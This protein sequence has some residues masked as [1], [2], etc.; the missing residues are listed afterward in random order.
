MLNIE[1]IQLS[2]PRFLINKEEGAT[3]SPMPSYVDMFLSNNTGYMNWFYNNFKNY[4][5]DLVPS[6]IKLGEKFGTIGIP[7]QE[8]LSQQPD[9]TIYCIGHL[10]LSLLPKRYVKPLLENFRILCVD[11]MEGRQFITS[12]IANKIIQYRNEYKVRE[13]VDQM[14]GPM[15]GLVT[16]NNV[17]NQYSK[18]VFKYNPTKLAVVPCH[19]PRPGRLFM[20]SEL[21]KEDLL[22]DCD[23]TLIPDFSEEISDEALE[24][25]KAGDGHFYLSPNLNFKKWPLLTDN[26]YKDIQNFLNTYRND[27]PKSFDNLTNNTFSDSCFSVSMDFLGAHMFNVSCETRDDICNDKDI[28]ITEKTFKAFLYATPCLV[29]GSPNIEKKLSNY[30][31]KFPSKS[32]YDHLH[33]MER[34]S[35]MVDFLKQDHNLDELKQ[36]AEHNFNIAWDRKFL[37]NLFAEHL[38]GS[39]I[40]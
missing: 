7:I 14:A 20:L 8:L 1:K 23:W 21:H 18:P 26:S 12:E 28:F 6:D 32:N 40:S 36:I 22:Q 9:D 16:Y 37:V 3:Y 39:W 30:G 29:Y 31:F 35:A 38:K 15:F 19:K 24:V 13:L 4:F 5:L 27:L 2:L 11:V 25:E 10:E 34:A 17:R 33:G